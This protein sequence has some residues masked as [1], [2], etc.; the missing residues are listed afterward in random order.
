MTGHGGMEGTGQGQTSRRAW[1]EGEML[2]WVLSGVLWTLN[3]LQRQQ[4]MLGGSVA[5]PCQ[6]SWARPLRYWELLDTHCKQQARL[7]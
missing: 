3:M 4:W 6:H 7:A 1:E 2:H 5:A